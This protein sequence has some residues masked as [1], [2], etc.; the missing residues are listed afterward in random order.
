[1]YVAQNFYRGNINEL[2]SFKSL[3]E[4][5]LMDNPLDNLFL[6]QARAAKGY[7]C[8]V[9][10]MTVFASTVKGDF[11]PPQLIYQGKIPKCLPTVSFPPDWHIYYNNIFR[12]PLVQ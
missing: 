8:L 10:I 4:E 5:L 3:T 11:L 7:A 9:Q 12:K 1:M 2:P 6:N